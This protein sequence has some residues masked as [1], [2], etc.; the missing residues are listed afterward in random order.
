M[1]HKRKKKN[2]LIALLTKTQIQD[3]SEHAQGADGILSYLG[4]EPSHDA[5]VK[6]QQRCIELGINI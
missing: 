2:T 6:L 3:A 5:R 1:E 4:F